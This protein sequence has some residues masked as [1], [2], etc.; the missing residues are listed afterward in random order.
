MKISCFVAM[1]ASLMSVPA[2]ADG[3]LKSEFGVCDN[4][5]VMMVITGVTNDRKVMRQYSQAIA[6]AGIYPATRGY[7]L[8]DPR[9]IAIFE[10]DIPENFT[11]LAVRFPCLA[12]AKAFWYSDVYQNKIKPIRTD[13]NAGNYTVTVYKQ[14]HLPSYMVGKVEKAPYFETFDHSPAADVPQVDVD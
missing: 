14:T 5:P 4:E 6:D 10:G 12:Y 3:H 8:N 1:A 13:A 11:T 7:Y 9:P 2:L